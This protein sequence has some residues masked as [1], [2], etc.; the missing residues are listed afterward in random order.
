MSESSLLLPDLGTHSTGS[1]EPR[2]EHRKVER[3]S[4]EELMADMAS[5]SFLAIGRRYRVWAARSGRGFAGK[6]TKVSV[7]VRATK[8]G[9]ASSGHER[10]TR[11][12][13]LVAASEPT[14]AVWSKGTT[15]PL[16]PH[17]LVLIREPV[18]SYL[19]GTPIPKEEP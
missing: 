12:G 18:C 17:G 19:G 2:P 9:Q 6:S 3:P 11:G 16:I 1:R 10:A 7:R 15:G 8:G 4:Y 5:I 14:G 13:A